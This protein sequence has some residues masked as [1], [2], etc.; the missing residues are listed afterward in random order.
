MRL[1]RS[2]K[3]AGIVE[4]LGQCRGVFSLLIQWVIPDFIS[5][6]SIPRHFFENTIRSQK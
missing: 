1:S 2:I 6:D 5:A 4:L 3:Y